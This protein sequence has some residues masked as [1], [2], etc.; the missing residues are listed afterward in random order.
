MS[1]YQEYINED[2][3]VRLRLQLHL[4]LHLR[5]HLNAAGRDRRGGTGTA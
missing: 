2:K 3:G 1:V 4:R 5:L